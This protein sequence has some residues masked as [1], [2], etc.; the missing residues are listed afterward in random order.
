MTIGGLSTPIGRDR[1]KADITVRRG[2]DYDGAQ[3]VGLTPDRVQTLAA[4]LAAGPDGP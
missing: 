2:N 3:Q 4:F 1:E